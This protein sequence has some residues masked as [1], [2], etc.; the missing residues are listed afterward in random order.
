MPTCTTIDPPSVNKGEYLPFW[1]ELEKDRKVEFVT[2]CSQARNDGQFYVVRG[3]SNE[4]DPLCTFKMYVDDTSR[5]PVA[6][7]TRYCYGD[8]QLNQYP[9]FADFFSDNPVSYDGYVRS[10]N[11]GGSSFFGPSAWSQVPEKYGEY[12]LSLD[13]ST[14]YVCE[15]SKNA[16]G[17]VTFK[18]SN[19]RYKAVNKA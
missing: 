10:K 5:V 4:T 7:F 6:E 3:Q 8:S 14:F 12:K 13:K 16:S 9:L 1:W 18:Q 11:K 15:S 19:T 17:T 2:N